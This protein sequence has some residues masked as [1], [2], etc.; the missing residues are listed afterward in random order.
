MAFSGL[1]ALQFQWNALPPSLAEVLMKGLLLRFQKTHSLRMLSFMLDSV[2]SWELKWAQLSDPLKDALRAA[3]L[4]STQ[5]GLVSAAAASAAGLSVPLESRQSSPCL[6]TSLGRMDA[7]WIELGSELQAALTRQL[8]QSLEEMSEVGLVGA[9]G[10]LASMG[11][12]WSGLK[13]SVKEAIQRRLVATSAQMGELDISQVVLSLSRLEVSWTDDLGEETKASLR[14]AI[15]RQ[16]SIGEHALSSLLY[17]L[18]QL[19]R[20]WPE[21]APEVRRALKE[22]IVTVHLND[23]CSAQ[24]V[25]YSLYGL[26][27]MGA[28]WNELSSS[29]RLALIKEVVKVAGSATDTQLTNIMWSLAR[30]GA[31]RKSFSA[32]LWVGLLAELERRAPAMNRQHLS[33]ALWSLGAMC[34][35]WESLPT[36]LRDALLLALRRVE[37]PKSMGALRLDYAN[38]VQSLSMLLA[39]L[40]NLHVRQ[41][42]LP[43]DLSTALVGSVAMF[44]TAMTAGQLANGLQ[45]LSKMGWQPDA[46]HAA[47]PSLYTALLRVLPLAEPAD[48]AAIIAGVS[49]ISLTWR[50]V[51]LSL[52]HALM[53]AAARVGRLGGPDDVS[54]AA[55]GLGSMECVWELMPER[56]RSELMGGIIRVSGSSRNTTP[57]AA[58]NLMYAVSLLCFDVADPRLHRDLVPVHLALL[59]SISVIGIG[60]FIEKERG[61][62]LIFLQF[63]R[64]LT[65]VGDMPAHRHII[66]VDQH[67]LPMSRL[68]MEVVHSLTEALELRNSSMTLENEYS[69]FGGTL[70][71]DATVFRG[72][73]VV[74]FIEIDGPH[75][76][77][78]GVLRRKD[79]LKEALY[80]KKHP[81]AVFARVK[82][83][84]IKRLGY[85]GVGEKVADFLAIVDPE[86]EEWANRRAERE[87]KLMLD[88]GRLPLYSE[89]G[90]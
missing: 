55:Y 45:G 49:G 8:R 54:L 1:Q 69:A 61:Q 89:D 41:Y 82:Y 50:T 13:S 23:V 28:Y 63:L 26:A 87:L 85:D 10:G 83:D 12:R 30:M 43:R 81:G 66:R 74:A 68:Q 4:H 17:G 37:A 22:A 38:R 77:Y 18:S 62:I 14:A 78:R 52:R 51:P 27:N 88:T 19:G 25:S 71:V 56:V 15:T 48:A 21:L 32:E 44:S 80:R 36:A 60:G 79:H 35:V 42:T 75:H 70:P 58:A 72:G 11:L 33:T 59:T 90:Y 67:D 7:R 40:G 86:R 64:H 9:L 57:Q 16:S 65:T 20:T 53:S 47:L 29:V 31:R 6:V 46:L 2:S 34:K 3:V 5:E 76:Y 24:G 73:R 84:C 39:G